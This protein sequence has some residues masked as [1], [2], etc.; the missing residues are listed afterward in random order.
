LFVVGDKVVIIEHLGV[1]SKA[2]KW[3]LGRDAN[4]KWLWNFEHKEKI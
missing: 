3:R 1:E 4:G 2:L